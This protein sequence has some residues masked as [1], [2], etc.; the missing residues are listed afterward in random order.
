MKVKVSLV[1]TQGRAA[2]VEYTYAKRTRRR[3]VPLTVVDGDSVLLEELEAG[4]PM[5]IDWE[6]HLDLKVSPE[7]LAAEFRSA[8]IWSMAD[9]DAKAERLLKIVSRPFVR[10]AVEALAKLR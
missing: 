5:S 3:L 6:D 8:G 7:E 2:L 9:V 10:Q 1:R 4:V